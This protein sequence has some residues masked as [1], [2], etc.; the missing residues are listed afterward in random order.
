MRPTAPLNAQD[1]GST[2]KPP[3][4]RAA[5]LMPFFRLK[6]WGVRAQVPAGAWNGTPILLCLLL[7]LSACSPRETPPQLSFTAAPPYTLTENRLVTGLYTLDTPSGWRVIAGPAQDP[8]TFQL[9]TPENDALIVVSDRGIDNPPMPSGADASTLEIA[10]A[11]RNLDGRTIYVV[12]VAP[13]A[14][15]DT[16]IP[17]RDAV[18][19]SLR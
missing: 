2:P 11:E 19:G 15:S 12:L 6:L 1:G 14:Q 7:L 13:R 9:I 4:G 18:V 17:I 3:Q 10:A 5:P 8:Y 16:L